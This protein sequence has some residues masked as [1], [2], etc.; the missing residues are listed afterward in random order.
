MV[1][2]KELLMNSLYRSLIAAALPAALACA[3]TVQ[4]EVEIGD[5]YAAEVERTMPI[6]KDSQTRSAFLSA[7]APLRRVVR[8]KEL[9]WDF[10][11]VNSDQVN[12][13][14]V[15]GGHIYIFRGLIERAAH[16][17]EFAGATAH[18]IGHVDLRH[19]AQQMG[20]VSAANTGLTLAYV[21]LGRRP[22]SAEQVAVGIAGGAVFAKFSRD[23]E[24]EADSIAVAYLTEANIDPNGLVQM[25]ERLREL[26][27]RD[28]SKVEL[29]FA[30]HPMPA[31][32]IT[33]TERYIQSTP[34]ARAATR[35]G[36][37]DTEA[38][39]ALQRRLRSLPAA[40]KDVQGQ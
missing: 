35:S 7:V 37:S 8:R 29:W 27:A 20:S 21:L 36:R 22:S 39:T 33:N 34:G 12:A 14:A 18:E 11:I 10:Q 38:F 6:I 23:D 1:V 30:S 3:P 17:D 40:P 32:R 31:E 9:N 2:C 25:F 13:F 24:R 26:Q 15:P 28:P 4:Q 16:W 5:Q 19:S